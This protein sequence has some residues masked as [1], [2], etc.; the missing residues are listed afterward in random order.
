M[1]EPAPSADATTVTDA[2]V[3]GTRVTGLLRYAF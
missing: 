1:P 3:T 2:I